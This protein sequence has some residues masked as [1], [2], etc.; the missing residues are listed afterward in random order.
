MVLVVKNSLTEANRKKLL[1]TIK[2]LI[3]GKFTKEEQW[4]EKVLS[5]QIKRQTSG[6]YVNYLFDMEDSLTNDLDKRLTAFED[7]LRHLILRLK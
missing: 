2:G 4:G 5:Y 3:K 1:E 6:F 7:V